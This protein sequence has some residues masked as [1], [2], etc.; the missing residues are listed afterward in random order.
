MS[1]CITL[2]NVI[3][4]YITLRIKA[5]MRDAWI[6]IVLLLVVVNKNYLDHVD[7]SY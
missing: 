5:W 7:D 2:N 1:V 3:A 4:M 6:D